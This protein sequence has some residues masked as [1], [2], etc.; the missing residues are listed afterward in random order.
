MSP[1]IF[2]DVTIHLGTA[3]SNLT[4]G[5]GLTKPNVLHIV[6]GWGGTEATERA[7][8]P[9]LRQ[10]LPHAFADLGNR[11]ILRLAKISRNEFL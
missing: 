11:G 6:S 9:L 10:A 1:F 5:N 4:T 8:R 3:T 7:T 2:D